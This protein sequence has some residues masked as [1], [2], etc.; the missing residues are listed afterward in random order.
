MGCKGHDETGQ[1]FSDVCQLTGIA[2]LFGGQVDRGN[3]RHVVPPDGIPFEFKENPTSDF[4]FG[5]FNIPHMDDNAVMYGGTLISLDTNSN[6]RTFNQF[7]DSGTQCGKSTAGCTSNF[8]LV[9]DNYPTELSFEFASSDTWFYYLYDVS[10]KSGIS[11]YPCFWLEDEDRSITSLGGT[12]TTEGPP[13]PETGEPTTNTEVTEPEDQIGTNSLKCYPCTNFN[14]TTDQV[15]LRYSGVRDLTGDPDCPHPT[16]FGLGSESQKVMFKYLALSTVA[17]DAVS[18]FTVGG[19]TAFPQGYGSKPGINH[20]TSQ[21]PWEAGEETFYN[22]Q[23]FGLDDGLS[24]GF[25]IRVGIAPR[26]DA[27]TGNIIGTKYSFDEWL[28]QGVRYTVG[29]T[30]TLNFDHSHP[31]GATTTFSITITVSGVEDA[32]IPDANTS[33]AGFDR[34]RVGDTVNGHEITRVMHSDEDFGYHVAYLSGSGGEFSN[35]STYTSDRNHQI[36]TY[37]G[38]GIKTHAALVGLYEFLGKSVQYT[39]AEIK[40]GAPDDYNVI[41][42]PV[43]ACEVQNG[44]IVG[45]VTSPSGDQ[46]VDDTGY[47]FD[48]GA[49]ITSSNLKNQ[50][51]EVVVTSPTASEGRQAVIE[52]Q[53]SG[54]S[55]TGIK[56]IDGGSGYSESA[57]ERPRVYIKNVQLVDDYV[58]PNNAVRKGQTKKETENIKRDPVSYTVDTPDGPLTVKDKGFPAKG[59][60]PV[61]RNELTRRQQKRDQKAIRAFIGDEAYD[62][63]LDAYDATQLAQYDNTPEDT[64]DES[65]PKGIEKAYKSR[66]AQTS[67]SMPVTK[68]NIRSDPDRYRETQLSQNLFYQEDTEPLRKYY[69]PTYPLN[70]L[71]TTDITTDLKNVVRDEQTNIRRTVSNHIDDMTLPTGAPPVTR[72]RERYI[73][74]VTGNLD[75]MPKASNSTKYMMTQYRPDPEKK[76]KVNVELTVT[77]VELGCGHVCPFAPTGRS[78]FTETIPAD[79]GDP[80]DNGFGT[81]YRYVYRMQGVFGSGCREWT[82]RGELEIFHDF[83]KSA[84]TV[85]NATER[86]GNPYDVEG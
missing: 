36:K 29:Q 53:F 72:H 5:G 14:C 80:Y 15:R 17:P 41:R 81:E 49:G 30:F 25:V 19:A 2:Y 73:E 84:Q 48:G 54:G 37:A 63:Q 66:K 35:G 9:Y 67:H 32:E 44:K 60:P 86:Y 11:G 21:N 8:Q 78:D 42:Q 26:I 62:A 24:T 85:A 20:F 68:L 75:Q 74:T 50:K 69:D 82:A 34:L 38:F 3:C 55:L 16:L 27:T 13:D 43:A 22:F 51:P 23:V 71:D 76:V 59:T 46:A 6:S 7:P 77:P 58:I 83:G 52:G 33:L 10:N 39:T 79:S 56:V 70:H 65:V 18:S 12:T 4:R 64:V 57:A 40:N 31:S 45:L 1:P 61:D 47:K 28:F